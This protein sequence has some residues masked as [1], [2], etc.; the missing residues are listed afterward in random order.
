MSLYTARTIGGGTDAIG[1]TLPTFRLG[2]TG[3]T[4]YNGTAD[5]SSTP[6]TPMDDGFSDGDIYIRSF[7]GSSSIWVYDTAVWTQ[8]ASAATADVSKVGTPVDDQIGVWTGDGTIEG[9]AD[10][11]FDGTALRAGGTNNYFKAEAGVLTVASADVGDP[12]AGDSITALLEFYDNNQVAQYATIG[13]DSGTEL[14]VRNLAYEGEYN[15]RVTNDVGVSTFGYNVAYQAFDVMLD[16]AGSTETVFGID[17]SGDT[18]DSSVISMSVPVEMTRTLSV[19]SAAPFIRQRNG[20][21][22]ADNRIWDMIVD[23]SGVFHLRAWNDAIGSSTD[24]MVINR[25]GT[26]IDS[27]FLNSATITINGTSVAGTLLWRGGDGTAALPAVSF[28]TDTA[29]GMFSPASDV[30][31]FSAAATEVFRIADTNIQALDGVIATPA[32]SFAAETNTGMFRKGA[33]LLGMVVLGTERMSLTANDAR[34]LEPIRGDGTANEAS[35]A[36]SFTSDDDTGMFQATANTIGFATGGIERLRINSNG[37]DV[38]GAVTFPLVSTAAATLT[39]DGTHFTVVG[40]LAGAQTFTLPTAVGITGRI[41]NIKKTGASGTLTVDTT[42]SQTIDG[43]LTF[44]NSTQYLSITV[45]S[46]GANWLII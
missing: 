24:A 6:P 25:T 17:T 27:I 26:V 33:G 41:Y 9:T 45:Q 36:Y 30:V 4:F 31:G 29:S 37:I 14:I 34:F 42:S 16:I 11:T 35:P 38:T 21:A 39:L 28:S 3:P 13:F 46:D 1:T 20:N 32:Y 15:L 5:P 18:F 10:L 7:S 2:L 19:E 44:A 43:S 22:A 8:I 12:T 23:T 40:T